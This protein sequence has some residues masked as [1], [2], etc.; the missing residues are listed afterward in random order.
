MRY[1]TGLRRA[2]APIVA[3]FVALSTSGIANAGV[4]ARQTTA[5]VTVTLTDSKLALSRTGLPAGPATFLVANKGK[6]VHVFSIEGP[7]IKG[8][9]IQTLQAGKT[10]SLTMPLKTGAYMLTDRIAKE[11]PLTRWI[12]VSPAAVVK[13]TGNA[14]VT[15]PLTVTTGMNCD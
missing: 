3:G 15:V 11:P 6:K 14:S 4:S 13:S 5:S 12:V 8:A 10:I 2:A 9:R 1:A 7:G